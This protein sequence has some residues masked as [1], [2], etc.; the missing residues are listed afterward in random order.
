MMQIQM[1]IS[2]FMHAYMNELAFFLLP[3]A[4]LCLC[5]VYIPVLLGLMASVPL[6][7]GMSVDIVVP[8]KTKPELKLSTLEGKAVQNIPVPV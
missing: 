4:L 1:W 7:S 2:R 3:C 8:W 6:V 5:T